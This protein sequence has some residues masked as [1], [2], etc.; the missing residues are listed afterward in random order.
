MAGHPIV[1][2][3]FASNDPTATSKFFAD[4]FGW[5]L[6]H[7]PEFDYTMFRAEGG[8]GG[9]FVK[10]DGAQSNTGDTLVYVGT[11]DIEGTL[12]QAESLGG[13]VIM[14]KMEIPN[15]GWFAIF[16]DPNGA[17]VALYT[18]MNQ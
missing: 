5:Q 14:P 3:E 2:V 12:R 8:P 16:T 9:G 7:A 11:D 17:R 10:A 15:T 4:L 13:K 18:E 1:H 6:Q